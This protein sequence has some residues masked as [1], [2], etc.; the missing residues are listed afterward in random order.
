M[1]DA[2]RAAYRAARTKDLAALDALSDQLLES[3]TSCHQ[4]YRP[5]YGRRPA[6]AASAAPIQAA[7]PVSPSPKI[8]GR[9]KIT[10]WYP[11]ATYAPAGQTQTV[12]GPNDLGPANG[13]AAASTPNGRLSPWVLLLPG[14]VLAA[15]AL[16]GGGYALLRWARQRSRV[17]ELR[18][19]LA[20]H[21]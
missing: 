16:G 10:T 2:G 4:H 15:I 20:G 11:V 8:D 3:C 7:P 6:P 1:L 13:A 5:N 9:W 12:L 19:S 18:R 17:R 14:G 21:R